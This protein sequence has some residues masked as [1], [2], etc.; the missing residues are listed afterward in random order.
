[1]R[2]HCLND[3]LP[4]A[5][6]PVA[7]LPGIVKVTGIKLSLLLVGNTE[8]GLLPADLRIVVEIS[9]MRTRSGLSGPV[10]VRVRNGLFTLAIRKRRSVA[11]L[12]RRVSATA[13]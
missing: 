7:Q 13:E 11:V 12:T 9:P 3:G 1:M 4:D 8:T 10:P 5:A 6:N 2:R